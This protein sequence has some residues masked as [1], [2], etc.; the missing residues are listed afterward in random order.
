MTWLLRLYPRAWRRRYEA[1]VAEMLASE[2][3][4]WRLGVDLLAGAVDA[5]ANPQWTP[6]TAE[7]DDA[8]SG[9][10]VCTYARTGYAPHR[11]PQSAAW[12]IGFSLVGVLIG[13]GLDSLY[14]DTAYT[15]AFMNS[16]FFVALLVSNFEGRDPK[17]YTV[18]ARTALVG[19]AACL[20]YGFFLG[21]QLLADLS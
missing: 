11:A 8:M 1:E 12:M 20:I 21:A 4:S 6:E 2:P 13:L 18:V 3:R 10:T 9:N 7:G 17:P 5:R 14:G 19:A 16:V 15:K